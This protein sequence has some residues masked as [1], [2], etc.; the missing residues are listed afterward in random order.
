MSTPLG[1]QMVLEKLDISQ[2]FK[3]R[4]IAKIVR[5]VNITM[6]AIIKNDVVET[7][8]W[9]RNLKQHN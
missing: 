2:R 9:T 4:P 5:K 3:Y 8:S 6:W 1:Q 7:Q